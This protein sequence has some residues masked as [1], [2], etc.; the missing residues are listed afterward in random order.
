M[1]E[2]ETLN[3]CLKGEGKEELGEGEWVSL[4]Y[5]KFQEDQNIIRLLYFPRT[6]EGKREEVF[7][8]F[9]MEESEFI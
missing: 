9:G 2:E 3:E 8:C 6:Q 7:V 1:V 5:L 4:R